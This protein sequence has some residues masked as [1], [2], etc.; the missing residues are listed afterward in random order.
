MN[1]LFSKNENNKN[2][3]KIFIKYKFESNESK[4][5]IFGD[6]FV[7]NNKNNNQS[8]WNACML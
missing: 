4:I 7:K 1:C 8:Y 6:I 3:Y 2:N 5:K